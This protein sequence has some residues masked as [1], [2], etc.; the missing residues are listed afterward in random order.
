M[1]IKTNFNKII[2]TKILFKDD[3]RNRITNRLK[4]HVNLI[5]LKTK[6]KKTLK[7]NFDTII[8]ISNKLA[9]I[10]DASESVFPANNNSLNILIFLS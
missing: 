5:K 9:N 4:L 1:S 6:F 8:K 2:K 10:L 7:K 3:S